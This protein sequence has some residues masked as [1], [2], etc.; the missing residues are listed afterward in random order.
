MVPRALTCRVANTLGPWRNHP[1]IAREYSSARQV[2]GIWGCYVVVGAEERFWKEKAHCAPLFT[3]GTWNSLD[4]FRWFAEDWKRLLKGG[5]ARLDFVPASIETEI[6]V[7]IPL[8]MGSKPWRLK[9]I[10]VSPVDPAKRLLFNGDWPV[11]M[12]DRTHVKEK[13][14]G[15]DAKETHSARNARELFE[16]VFSE[17]KMAT[18]RE[19]AEKARKS[20]H[21]PVLGAQHYFDAIVELEW[22]EKVADGLKQKFMGSGSGES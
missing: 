7:D 20:R 3:N 12:E 1:S 21:S 10:A 22:A 19:H 13:E 15:M 14:K 4:L 5:T 2:P 11:G 17:R 6:A 18:I 16:Q 8:L 9:A